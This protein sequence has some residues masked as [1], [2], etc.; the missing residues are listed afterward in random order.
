MRAQQN[1]MNVVADK[2]YLRGCSNPAVPRLMSP[3][4]SMQ[5]S[6]HPRSVALHEIP[7]AGAL[8]GRSATFWCP[9]RHV[10]DSVY[11]AAA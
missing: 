6:P 4:S 11:E 1:E 5:I 10:S 3:C 8:F 9:V 7:R 2:L